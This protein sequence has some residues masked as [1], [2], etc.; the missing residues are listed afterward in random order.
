M[1]TNKNSRTT[2]P[3]KLD[4]YVASI[5]KLFGEPESVP[6]TIFS[7]EKYIA[8]YQDTIDAAIQPYK[9]YSDY[10]PIG[11]EFEI[12]NKKYKEFA[13]YSGGWMV[14][15]DPGGGTIGSTFWH[16]VLD[17]TYGPAA[18]HVNAIIKS[19]ISYDHVLLVPWFDVGIPTAKT[20]DELQITY[21][22]TTISASLGQDILQGKDSREWP[23]DTIDHATRYINGFDSSR[24]RYLFV[25]W[26]T[27]QLGYNNRIKFEVA[28]YEMERSNTDTGL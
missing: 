5:K 18:I 12:N 4:D 22:N 16:D 28:L 9:A 11:F 6:D 24:G 8:T 27:S 13:V 20:I 19:S 10:K 17:T 7:R 1:A 3:K 14:L 2:A 26:T 23:Y 21:Y 25:R 15:K